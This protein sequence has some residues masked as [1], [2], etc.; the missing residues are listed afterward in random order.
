[1]AGRYLFNSGDLDGSLKFYSHA[2]SKYKT[3]G[4]NAIVARVEY[5]VSQK[6]GTVCGLPHGKEIEFNDS[7]ESISRKR[8][9]SDSF[10]DNARR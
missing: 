9:V 10:I 6:F 5:E 4:A 1:M 8:Q 3:W 2:I 7:S